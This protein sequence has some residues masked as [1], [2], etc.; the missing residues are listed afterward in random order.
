VRQAIS[1]AGGFAKHG[2]RRAVHVVRVVEGRRS[3]VKVALDDPLLPDDTIV[4][5]EGL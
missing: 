5:G 2:S 1:L 4:V 3:Q